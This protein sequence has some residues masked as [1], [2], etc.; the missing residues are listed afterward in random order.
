MSRGDHAPGIPSYHVFS[1]LGTEI[2]VFKNT[3]T[4]RAEL[5]FDV[6]GSR[7][8]GDVELPGYLTLDFSSSLTILSSAR[9]SFQ[10]NNILNERYEGFPGFLMPK[11]YFTIGLFW[12]LFD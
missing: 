5:D 11:R 9:V 2:R 7:S 6:T 8:F 4:L 1:V 12:E 10:L 3:E